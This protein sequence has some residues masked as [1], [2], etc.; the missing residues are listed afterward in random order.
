MHMGE[1]TLVIKLVLRVW[2]CFMLEAHLSQTYVLCQ[3]ELPIVC[4]Q[5]L[6]FSTKQCLSIL[7]KD[8]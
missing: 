1:E 3:T 8:I 2:M 7:E 4:L 5:L 6:K